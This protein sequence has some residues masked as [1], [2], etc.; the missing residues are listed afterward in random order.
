MTDQTDCLTSH[1][2]PRLDHTEMVKMNKAHRYM[3]P[4]LADLMRIENQ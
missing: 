1:F 3:Y 4:E 2:A